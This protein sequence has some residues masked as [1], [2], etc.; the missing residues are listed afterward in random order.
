MG[1]V[2][3]ALA[4]GIDAISA[5]S[6]LKPRPETKDVTRAA[7]RAAASSGGSAGLYFGLYQASKCVLFNSRF[8]HGMTE[9]PIVG[10][11]ALIA[12]V[13]VVVVSKPHPAILGMLVLLDNSH[14]I[15]GA[16]KS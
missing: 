8:K 14:L 9:L 3:G 15:L 16:R 12:A 7:L 2:V 13:P 6:R 10:C 5:A 4:G 1:G 11:A